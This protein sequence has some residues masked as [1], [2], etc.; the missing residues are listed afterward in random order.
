MMSTRQSAAAAIAATWLAV[1][2]FSVPPLPLATVIMLSIAKI[3]ILLFGRKS[4]DFLV[5]DR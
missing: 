1:V 4:A 5:Y 2:L 3:K